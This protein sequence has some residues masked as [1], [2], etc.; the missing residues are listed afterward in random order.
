[1]IILFNKN[2]LLKL[3]YREEKIGANDWIYFSLYSFMIWKGNL[4]EKDTDYFYMQIYDELQKRYILDSRPLISFFRKYLGFGDRQSFN[5]FDSLPKIPKNEVLYIK[6]YEVLKSNLNSYIQDK[7]ERITVFRV[8]DSCRY[9]LHCL[10]KY[11]LAQYKQLHFAKNLSER[12][13]RDFLSSYENITNYVHS[14]IEEI[15]EEKE[16]DPL[17]IIIS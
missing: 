10:D 17:I 14:R 16:I 2:K 5:I 8:E 15:L 1:M 13:K 4:F 3:Y 6:E 9:D 7:K 12:I 11:D